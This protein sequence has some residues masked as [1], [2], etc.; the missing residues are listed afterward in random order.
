MIFLPLGATSARVSILVEVLVRNHRQS[1]LFPWLESD[2]QL[3]AT[4][5]IES[6]GN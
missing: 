3:D 2:F 4:E 6:V 1:L 5:F